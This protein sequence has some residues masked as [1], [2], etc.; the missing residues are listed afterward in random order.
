MDKIMHDEIVKLFYEE[1]CKLMAGELEAHRSQVKS[2]K[3]AL[4]R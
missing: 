2:L 3:G 4:I 1:R